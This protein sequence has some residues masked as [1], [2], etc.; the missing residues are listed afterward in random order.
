MLLAVHSRVSQDTLRPVPRSAGR[1]LGNQEVIEDW[2]SKLS[3]ERQVCRDF[4]GVHLV[5]ISLN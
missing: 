5:P 4:A 2:R 3:P 1:I